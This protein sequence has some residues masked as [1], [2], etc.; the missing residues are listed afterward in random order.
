MSTTPEP[1][2][3]LD[4]H[5]LP[6]WARQA[7]D[8]NRYSQF[9]GG[10][11]DD[12]SRRGGRDRPPGEGRRPGPGGD[13]SAR[14]PG[15]PGRGGDRRPGG[16]DRDR[17]RDR[18]NRPPP[19][20][21]APPLPEIGVNFVPDNPGVESLARQI[22]VTGRAYPVFEIAQLVLSKPERYQVTFSELKGAEGQ[23]LQG[24]WLCSIDNTLWLSVDEAVGHVM[25]KHFELFYQ[26]EKTPTDPPKGTY[27]FVAQ[28]GLSGT[29]LGPP[30]FHDYQAKLCKLHAARFSRMPLEAYKAKIRMVRDEAVVKQWIE[31]QS[32]KTE[33]N[34]LNVPE[35]RKLA[36]RDEAEKHFR[37]VHAPSLI[38]QVDAWTASAAL[39]QQLPCTRLRQILRYAWEDQ[40][41][42]PLR[43]VTVLSQQL[44]G[45]GL[46]F[47]KVNKT[48]THVCV[49]R[50]HHLDME[51][52]PVSEGIRRIVE[53]IDAHEGCRRRELVE[54]LAPTPVAPPPPEPPSSA[55]PAPA[56]EGTSPPPPAAA[57]AAPPPTP[58]Q[59]SIISDL[60]WLIHQGH[61]V[62]FANGRLETAKKPKP[63]PE[64]KPQAA[65]KPQAVVEA[66]HSA[67]PA[68]ETA[69]GTLP[70]A[71]LTGPPSDPAGSPPPESAAEPPPEPPPAESLPAEP[72]AGEQ[73]PP[74]PAP[75]EPP[76]TPGPEP[77]K[78]GDTGE[79]KASG[80][81]DAPA[82]LDRVPASGVPVDPRPT[83]QEPAAPTGQAP[84]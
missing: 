49:A 61:V 50:P 3:D 19:R 51:A 71:D 59:T 11:R 25:R 77:V 80:S 20:E 54:T 6:A 83:E 48:V 28:C 63:R 47:F 79:P 42:F 27:T 12:R 46:Q 55:E 68:A 70:T 40:R 62:E 15:G 53:Y 29:I 34:C 23:L 72:G 5:F 2:M 52:S 65:P 64:P 67:P 26:A 18:G 10:G 9:E 21:A 58:E 81:S 39:A 30:N 41:R 13:R 31:D 57:S 60:H 1:D 75:Q 33:F 22:K 76:I 36:N 45:H 73:A 8:L 74:E 7:P 24:L 35:P 78:P 44:A 14:R 43:V 4:L 56:P 32:F 37:E 69:G 16:P 84:G 17:D 82:E 38:Q 66:S